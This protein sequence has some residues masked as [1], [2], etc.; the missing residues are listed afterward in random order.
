MITHTFIL[1]TSKQYMYV[2]GRLDTK[3]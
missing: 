2:N 3:G 1:A